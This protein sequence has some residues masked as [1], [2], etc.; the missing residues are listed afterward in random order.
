MMYRR[1]LFAGVGAAIIG[2]MLLTYETAASEKPIK[3]EVGK[4]A[5]QFEGRLLD[6]KLFKLEDLLEKKD[7]LVLVDFWA[8]WC[9]PCRAEIPHLQ[10]VYKE[11]QK[12]GLELV[13]VNVNEGGDVIEKFIKKTPMPWKHIRD[14]NGK[15]SKLYEVNAIPAPFLI[16]Q[17]GVLIAMGE[18]LRGS[19]LKKTIAKHIKNLPEKEI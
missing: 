18:D 4:T 2:I 11:F 9:P 15:I 7:K 13:S 17:N 1:L 19:R 12:K 16:D 8:T 5:P 6:K 10:E 14:I 3:P